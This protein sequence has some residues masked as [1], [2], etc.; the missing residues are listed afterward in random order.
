MR[1]PS[2]FSYYCLN[3]LAWKGSVTIQQE[4][5]RWKFG[6]KMSNA[7]ELFV[8]LILRPN[9]KKQLNPIF[10]RTFTEMSYSPAP[11]VLEL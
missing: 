7:L 4:A 11:A 3:I 8:R 2:I 10:V 5:Y 1:H 9:S 6:R